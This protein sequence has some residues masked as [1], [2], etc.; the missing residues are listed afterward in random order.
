MK[1]NKLIIIGLVIIILAVL[2]V[3]AAKK[4]RNNSIQKQSVA[5]QSVQVAQNTDNKMILFVGTGCPHCKIVEDYIQQNQIDSKISF[6][7]KE[8]FYDKG[9]QSILEEKAK[10]CKLD[11]NSI[12]VPLLWT[13]STCLE[14]DQPI[15]DFF[16]KQINK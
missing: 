7:Q 9:N 6:D 11:L 2:G 13:G 1:K 16:N 10:I 4:M 12:G 3:F 14:G 15:I 5:S 8:V